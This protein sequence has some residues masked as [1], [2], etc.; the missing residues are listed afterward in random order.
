MKL[1]KDDMM[2]FQETVRPL[3]SIADELRDAL[4]GTNQFSIRY[5]PVIEGKSG[6]VEKIFPSTQTSL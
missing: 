2:I 1:F 5:Q 4:K 3:R 6:K